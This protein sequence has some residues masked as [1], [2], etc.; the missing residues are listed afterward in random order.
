M[1]SVQCKNDPKCKCEC[2][3]HQAIRETSR[4]VETE[5]EAG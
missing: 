3:D 1:T 2:K 5:A 4:Q